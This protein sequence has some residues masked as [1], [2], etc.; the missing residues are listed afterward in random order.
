MARLP[1]VEMASLDK[2]TQAGLKAGEQMLGFSPNDGLLMAHNRALMQSFLQLVQTI[3]SPGEVS[4][5]LKR[6]VGLVTSN[7][8]GCIYC[9]AHTSFSAHR[10]GISEEKLRHVWSF[11]DSPLFSDAERVA[12]TVAMK[13]GQSP[14]GVTDADFA[15]LGEHFSVAAQ[16]E[17]VAVISM[18]G[19]LN[20]WNS[21]LNTDLEEAP[22]ALMA[23]LQATP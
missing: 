21:T 20:R 10:L 9:Q 4:P 19:F 15:A 3:Y 7:A 11:A 8:A 23:K 5:E 2:E 6:L 14:N 12:L 22:A 17:I 18:F 16:V 13:G 1:A